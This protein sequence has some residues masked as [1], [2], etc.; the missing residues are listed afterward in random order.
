LLVAE[1]RGLGLNEIARRAGLNKATVHRLLAALKSTGLVVQ[2]RSTALYRPGLKLVGMAEQVLQA[3]DFRE[4]A[5]P[6]VERLSRELGHGVLSG[7]LEGAQIVY[8]DHA[9]GRHALRVHRQVGE[10]VSVHISS[11]AK[12]ILAYL[13]PGEAAGVIDACRFERYTERTLADADALRRQLSAVRRL[14]WALLRDEGALGVA[15]IGAPVF[16]HTGRVVGA[17][18]VSVPSFMLEGAMLERTVDRLLEGCFAA[19]A[20][21]GHVRPDQGRGLGAAS[22]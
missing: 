18:G 11:M 21:L 2:D 12:A 3:L 22:T 9:P 20:D 10:R 19:S 17:I 6:H 14:G 8:L 15:S 5:R 13:P 16:D 7:V 4:V 1:P